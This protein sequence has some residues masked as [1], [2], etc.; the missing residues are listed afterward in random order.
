MERNRQALLLG[1]AG[2]ASVLAV[3]LALQW[4]NDQKTIHELNVKLVEAQQGEALAY[5]VMDQ[6]HR[7]NETLQRAMNQHV[8]D[9]I[10]ASQTVTDRKQLR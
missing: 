4:G 2:I 1:W 9:M 3:S 5:R 8:Q 10:T 6:Q 7:G